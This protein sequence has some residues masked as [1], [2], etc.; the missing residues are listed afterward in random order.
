MRQNNK[1]SMLQPEAHSSNDYCKSDGSARGRF[2]SQPVMQLLALI[3]PLHNLIARGRPN[4]FAGESFKYGWLQILTLFNQI[5]PCVLL[6]VL[7]T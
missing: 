6:E 5:Q 2:D 3:G 7:Q 4:V 1:Y